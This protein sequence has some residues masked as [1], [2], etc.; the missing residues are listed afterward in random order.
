[1]LD[2]LDAKACRSTLGA[3]PIT[4]AFLKRDK[5]LAAVTQF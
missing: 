5:K 3:D 2:E 1:M 4:E